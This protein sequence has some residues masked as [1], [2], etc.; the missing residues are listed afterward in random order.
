M[1]GEGPWSRARGLGGNTLDASGRG[2]H[3]QPI[4]T[5]PIATQPE[6]R[7]LWQM[8]SGQGPLTEVIMNTP[9]GIQLAVHV[10]GPT[11]LSMRVGI[12]SFRDN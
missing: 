8:G 11:P 6:I 4:C 7:F 2:G 3:D 5:P 1:E 12:P 9:L 10:V